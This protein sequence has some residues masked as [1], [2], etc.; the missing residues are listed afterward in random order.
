[1]RLN[2]H[3]LT[4]YQKRP[5]TNLSTS[6]NTSK[7]SSNE[8]F[9]QIS[10]ATVCMSPSGA[11]PMEEL[12]LPQDVK[13]SSQPQSDLQQPQ[14]QQQQQKKRKH[15]IPSIKPEVVEQLS[16]LAANVTLRL[17]GTR[18]RMVMQQQQQQ[19][20]QRGWS[21]ETL[22]SSSSSSSF[23]D[24]VPTNNTSSA[25]TKNFLSVPGQQNIPLTPPQSPHRS[26]S[27][28]STCSGTTAAASSHAPAPAP[29]STQ[30]PQLPT[31]QAPLPPTYLFHYAHRLRFIV[32]HTLT[33]LNASPQ[34]VPYALLL[35]KRLVSLPTLPSVLSNP[36]RLLMGALIVADACLRDATLPSGVWVNILGGGG[37][38]SKKDVAEWKTAVLVGLDWNVTVKEMEFAEWLGRLKGWVSGGGGNG[39]VGSGSEMNG[40]TVCGGSTSVG[41]AAAAKAAAAGVYQGVKQGYMNIPVVVVDRVDDHKDQKVTQGNYPQAKVVG[42]NGFLNVPAVK[43]LHA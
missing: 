18:W 6:I 35:V 33:H 29:A 24:A 32:S 16:C 2:S 4:P 38:E 28:S 40:T 3:R 43:V 11:E 8:E 37:G 21:D 10:D 17:V 25:D 22:C 7:P 1:M 14:H 5:S 20:Q 39:T 36:V 9:T 26:N 31:Q 27:T 15:H 41:G 30:Q 42:G 23:S 19:Q 12:P 13:P 34:V